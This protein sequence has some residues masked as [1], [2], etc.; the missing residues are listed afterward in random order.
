MSGQDYSGL[1]IDPGYCLSPV[2]NC[3]FHNAMG[4]ISELHALYLFVAL[5]RRVINFQSLVNKHQ[6][7]L[8]DW[9]P[10]NGVFPL[11][12]SAPSSMSEV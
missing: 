5:T 10:F 8:L 4:I 12:S 2:N 9:H 1:E 3:T 11:R 6:S 7:S